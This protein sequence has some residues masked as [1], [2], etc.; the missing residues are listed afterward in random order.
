MHPLFWV[1]I[2][3]MLDAWSHFDQ[4]N[5]TNPTKLCWITVSILVLARYFVL[6]QQQPS[7]N[8]T[9][10]DMNTDNVFL[11]NSFH[12]APGPARV[13]KDV[14]ILARTITTIHVAMNDNIRTAPPY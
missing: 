1:M 3:V 7:N 6:R 9:D 4:P 10:D 14:T 2:G 8:V 5:N 12:C 11:I 13:R